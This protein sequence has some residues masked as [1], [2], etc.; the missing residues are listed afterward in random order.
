MQLSNVLFTR[1]IGQVID[2]NDAL[3]T[4]VHL[5]HNE[6]Q[7][8]SQSVS[9]LVGWLVAPTTT[10][11]HI[12]QTKEFAKS[13]SRLKMQRVLAIVIQCKQQM[14]LFIYTPYMSTNSNDVRAGLLDCSVHW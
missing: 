3:C 9:W 13:G 8:V 2:D 12:G 6:V 4:A 11:Y 1:W 14:L 10:T 7:S 5:R